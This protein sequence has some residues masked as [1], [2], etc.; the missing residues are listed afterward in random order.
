MAKEEK[1]CVNCK[2]YTSLAGFHT[3]SIKTNKISPITGKPLMLEYTC[4]YQ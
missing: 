2:N 3:C 1:F 4:Q